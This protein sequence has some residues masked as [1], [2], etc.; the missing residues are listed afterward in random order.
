MGTRGTG[1]DIQ[2]YDWAGSSTVTFSNITR[3]D[4]L[5]EIAYAIGA[6][7]RFMLFAP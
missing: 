7:S 4:V 3:L 2:I 5:S 1:S 6:G